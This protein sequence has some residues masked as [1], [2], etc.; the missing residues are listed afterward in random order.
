MVFRY[1]GLLILFE[2]MAQVKCFAE[3]SGLLYFACL[4]RSD[5]VYLPQ[6]KL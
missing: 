4:P 2:D 5:L 3:S 1:K 6:Y